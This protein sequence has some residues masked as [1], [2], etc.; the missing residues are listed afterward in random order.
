MHL[1]LRMRLSSCAHILEVGLLQVHTLLHE[2]FK[3]ICTA[4]IFLLLAR[5]CHLFIF[6]EAQ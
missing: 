2:N 5:L 3:P 1:H 6:P 4:G